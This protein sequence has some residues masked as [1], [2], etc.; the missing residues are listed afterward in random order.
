M[1]FVGLLQLPSFFDNNEH[2]FKMLD[3]QN[4]SS[5]KDIGGFVSLPTNFP[6]III[7]KKLFPCRNN[8]IHMS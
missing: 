6:L 1:K 5:M 2:L 8:V 3:K 7:K 4:N